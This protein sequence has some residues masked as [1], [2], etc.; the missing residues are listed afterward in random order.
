MISWLNP[1]YVPYEQR[2][3]SFMLALFIPIYAFLSLSVKWFMRWR[4]S[5]D[6][7]ESFLMSR[8]FKN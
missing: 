7:Y 6:F 8:F 1:A 3:S 5:D 4:L 2:G